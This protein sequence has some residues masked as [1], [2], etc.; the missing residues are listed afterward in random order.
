MLKSLSLLYATAAAL[1]LLL[2][3]CGGSAPQYKE[4]TPQERKES[5][6]SDLVTD[7]LRLFG[8]RG[9]V[10]TVSA[11]NTRMTFMPNGML[12]SIVYCGD[13]LAVVRNNEGAILRLLD[14][15][16]QELPLSEIT[17][18]AAKNRHIDYW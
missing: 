14:T 9:V 18:A 1:P 13:S 8:L 3:A 10:K 12:E 2:A 16:G 4:K 15:S 6:H 5:Y 11:D 17:R 7:D